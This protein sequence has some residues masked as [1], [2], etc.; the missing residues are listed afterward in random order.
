[1]NRVVVKLVRRS[2]SLRFSFG[3]RRREG[4][5]P[6]NWQEW[7]IN[8]SYALEPGLAALDREI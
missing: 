5:K 1:M 7:S 8:L 3:V 2:E 4:D 6:F